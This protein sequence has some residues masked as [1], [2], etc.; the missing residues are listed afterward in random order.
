MNESTH[1][2]IV[3]DDASRRAFVCQTAKKHGVVASH[4]SEAADETGAVSI[5][6]SGVP[7]HLA[8]IDVHLTPAEGSEGFRLMQLVRETHPTCRVIGISSSIDP[9][10]GADVMN[11]AKADDYI[12]TSVI[13]IPWRKYCAER[14]RIGFLFARHHQA[15]KVLATG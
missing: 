10:V 14:L 11:I 8:C 9:S 13:E 2:L 4:I 6:R 12:Q 7:I 3:D 1:V 15:Q 5:I